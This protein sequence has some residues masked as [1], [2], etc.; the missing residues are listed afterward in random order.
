MLQENFQPHPLPDAPRPP[1]SPEQIPT[2]RAE[3]RREIV[4]AGDPVAR[5]EPI[6]V[7]NPGFVTRKQ[8][9]GTT[10]AQCGAKT[11]V[12]PGSLPF[13]SGP[14]KGG[15]LCPDCWTLFWDEH[16]ELLG[17][18]KSRAVVAEEARRI[19][20]KRA[21]DGSELIVEDTGNR[22]FYTR[23][24]TVVI[25]LKRLPFGGADEYDAQRIATMRR[26]LEAAER[27]L[28]AKTEAQ[29]SA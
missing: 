21:G 3:P 18:A 9:I 11:S 28:H 17:D 22:A 24:G 10:C 5:A 25:D 23:R 8:P 13:S 15:F 2:V 27:H 29:K 20:L 16:P 26:L 4:P 14:Y 6:T 12:K 19:R 1:L 7:D